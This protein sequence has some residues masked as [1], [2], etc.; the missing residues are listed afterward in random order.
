MQKL[1][2][3]RERRRL[4]TVALYINAAN[5]LGSR[6]I[7]DDL[8]E[9]VR[10]W[11]AADPDEQSRASLTEQLARGDED[12]LRDQFKGFLKFGTAGLRGLLGEGP[13]RMNRAVVIRATAGLCAYLL[14][15]VDGAKERGIVIGYDGRRMSDVFAEDVAQVAAGAGIKAL[16]F[17]HVTPTPLVGFSV[18][19]QNAAAGVVITAS[20]NPP[21]YNGYKVF[22]GNGAQII[23][24]HDAGIARWIDLIK[25]AR[26]VPRSDTPRV[27]LSSDIV[28]RYHEAIRVL[29]LSPAAPRDFAIA[30]TAMHGVGEEHVLRAL[31]AGGFERVHSVAEQ[32]EPDGTFPTVTFPNPE[33]KGATDLVLALARENN[34]ELVLANDPD[35][36]RLAVT[37]RH[38]GEYVALSGNEIGCLLAHYLLEREPAERRA[39]KR[40]VV[41]SMVS[42]P[43][44]GAIARHHGARWEET[45]T[46]HK[47]IQNVALDRMA[48]GYRYV[49]GYEEAIGYGA[50]NAVRDKDGISA[51]LVMSDMAAWCCAQ[52]RTLIDELERAWRTYGM[53]L[54]RQEARMLPGDDGAKAIA[55]ALRVARENPPSEIGG[56][57]ITA[58]AD[59]LKQERFVD[60]VK[61]AT[62]FPKANVLMFELAGGHRVMLRPSGTEPKIKNY[63]DVRVDMAEGE[64]VDDAKARGEA[65]LDRISAA[66]LNHIGLS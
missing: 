60:G 49:F 30:Y 32:A 2:L 9:L 51:A 27:T 42:S 55:Q 35:A 19:D 17:P 33:E 14:E 39:D 10:D 47:W 5:A 26:D 6:V 16:V 11:I 7:D 58:R 46:G 65:L 43:M 15:T 48:E 28:D 56:L 1:T 63:F 3:T 20:H 44:L 45:L 66:F 24:P 57:K 61:G 38:E 36:D 52:G 41:S 31:R 62:G 50:G 25:N 53:F 21:D 18:L 59:L 22:F 37:A 29:P 4:P 64:S 8:Q 23:P 40:L 34:A 12:G 13:N 54:S